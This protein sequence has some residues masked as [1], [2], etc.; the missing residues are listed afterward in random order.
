MTR[1]L[2]GLIAAIGV[3]LI[4]TALTLPHRQTPAVINAIA[5]GGTHLEEASLG[6][7]PKGV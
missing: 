2:A 4:I 6:M 3:A 7:V 5:S 1:P